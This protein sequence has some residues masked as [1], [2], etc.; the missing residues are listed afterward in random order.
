MCLTQNLFMMTPK[1]L[2]TGANGH[3]GYNLCQL[4]IDRGE[5]VIAT[6]RNPQN[7]SVLDALPCEK[8]QV[9]MMAPASMRD[10]FDGVERIYAVGASFKMWARN[11]QRDI[12]ENNVTGTRH[13]FEAAAAC[14]VKHIVYV[15]SVAA[16]DFT[17]LPA[18]EGNGYN[19]DRRN[20]YYNS[21]NDSDKL[22]L[23][24][25]KK[26][27]IRTVLILPSAMIGRDA[28]RLSYSNKLVYQI[29]NGEMVADTSITLNWIDVKDV[30]MGAYQAMT[31]G[32][33]GE[34]YIL[35][36][37]THTSI[38]ESVEIAADLFPELKLNIPPKVPKPLLYLIAICMELYSKLFA[39]EPLLQRQYL[40]MFHGLKQDYDVSK[41]QQE[42]M[43]D[44]KPSKVALQEALM[45]LKNEWRGVE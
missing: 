21:K 1:T 35:A 44:P 26:H 2:V 10:T 13:L 23:A 27:N 45:Y 30:A 40:D 22:A 7:Q 19:K 3:L 31:L 14:G 18:K 6:Y 38:Q 20:I 24:L 32:R 39:K 17:R 37:E 36:N 16:L 29:L 15:S 33:D 34:R 43:F 9:D 41:A 4:L 11:P 42:L 8:A 25:G 12:Y 5:Q 28:H